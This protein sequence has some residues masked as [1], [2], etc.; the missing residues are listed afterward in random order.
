MAK[1]KVVIPT[2]TSNLLEE[3]FVCDGVDYG[4]VVNRDGVSVP[5]AWVRNAQEG[6]EENAFVGLC[7]SV[8]RASLYGCMPRYLVVSSLRSVWFVRAHRL[9]E[10]LSHN[11]FDWSVGVTSSCVEVSAL[12]ELFRDAVHCVSRECWSTL[13]GVYSSLISDGKL[14]LTEEMLLWSRWEWDRLVWG[15]LQSCDSSLKD[16]LWILSVASL[17]SV[18]GDS[19]YVS[20]GVGFVLEDR[21]VLFSDHGVGFSKWASLFTLDSRSNFS[22][23]SEHFWFNNACWDYSF[24]GSYA[25]RSSK[26]AYYTPDGWVRLSQDLLRSVLSE[27]LEEDYYI[28]DC[29]A[30]TGNL[31]QGLRG[32]N[33]FASTL[34]EADVDAMRCRVD[35]GELRLSKDNIFAFD[36]LNGDWSLLPPRLRAVVEDPVARRRLIIYMNPP[37]VGAGDIRSFRGGRTIASDRSVVYRNGFQGRMQKKWGS[38]PDLYVQFILRCYEDLEGC[39]VG[40]FSPITFVSNVSF[41][42]FRALF[43]GDYRGGF[44]V[45][46][47]TFDNV[48]SQFPIA[49]TVWDMGR[50]GKGVGDGLS[51]TVCPVLGSMESGFAYTLASGDGYESLNDG[52]TKNVDRWGTV[53]GYIGTKSCVFFQDSMIYVH[54]NAHKGGVAITSSNLFAVCVYFAVRLCHLWPWWLSREVYRWS[55]AWEADDQFKLDCLWFMQTSLQNY[56]GGELG[57]GWYPFSDASMLS[58]L[59]AQGYPHC[60]SFG[61]TMSI[62]DL[63]LSLEAAGAR[64]ALAALYAYYHQKVGECGPVTYYGVRQFFQGKDSSRGVMKV[65]SED[66]E[67]ERLQGAVKEANRVLGDRIFQKVQAYGFLSDF[68]C[69]WLD[70]NN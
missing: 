8:G 35:S 43:K 30:G 2:L 52:L 31:L 29:A 10:L 28:W 64:D 44:L 53:L 18:F 46:S 12:K 68:V 70:L 58:K 62:S 9:F 16:R 54:D 33:V 42:K 14:C 13:V 36:F 37:Y 39:N 4:L 11:D 50:H 27:K 20:E 60:D 48:S 47:N 6:N 7:L 41:N 61:I 66:L 40:V 55:V 17:G 23:D 65:K 57:L 34:E 1:K 69:G 24:F 15:S 22:Y 51:F 3:V 19:E 45:N 49:F 26:G 56:F 63:T 5:Y 25:D 67:Y 59:E 38:I 32:E 21:G